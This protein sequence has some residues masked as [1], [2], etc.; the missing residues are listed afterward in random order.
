MNEQVES[1]LNQHMAVIGRV[2]AKFV[3]EGLLLH[4]IDSRGAEKFLGTDEDSKVF[5]AVLV[6][7]LDEGIIRAKK[8]TPMISGGVIHLSGAQLTAKGLAIVKQPLP[9]GETIEKR[10]QSAGTDNSLYSKI[11]DL[12]GSAAGSFTKSLGSG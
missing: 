6:W 4:D 11:G 8:V 5:A 10:I 12:I 9:E 7:M 3:S 2:I 1:A